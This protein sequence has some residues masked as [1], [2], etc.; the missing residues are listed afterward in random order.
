MKSKAFY[1]FAMLG[2]NYINYI[3]L[4]S[5][6]IRLKNTKNKKE[7]ILYTKLDVQLLKRIDDS[8]EFVLDVRDSFYYF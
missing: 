4:T 5:I 6:P 2:N 8:L 7:S 1:Y 3:N